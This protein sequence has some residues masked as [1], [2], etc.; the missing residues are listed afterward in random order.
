MDQVTV[1][2]SEPPAAV[3]SGMVSEAIAAAMR[4]G[5]IEKRPGLTFGGHLLKYLEPE[6]R[7]AK[8]LWMVGRALEASLD[9]RAQGQGQ[10]VEAI[11]GIANPAYFDS[12]RLSG[13]NGRTRKPKVT[14]WSEI[15]GAGTLQVRWRPTRDKVK[16][17]GESVSG[18][19]TD[20]V[21]TPATWRE[22]GVADNVILRFKQGTFVEWSSGQV[23]EADGLVA[24]AI[25][26]LRGALVETLGHIL[27]AL[28]VHCEVLV[29]DWPEYFPDGS[30]K[31]TSVRHRASKGL[32]M[33]RESASADVRKRKEDVDSRVAKLGLES[34]EQFEAA[35]SKAE[36]SGSRL[37]ADLFAMTGQRCTSL[38][39][40]ALAERLDGLRAV[41][42]L[43]DAIERA[44]AKLAEADEALMLG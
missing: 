6:P 23:T 14:L 44:K 26:G 21:F 18:V 37:T 43:L 1:E 31:L 13:A 39:T 16:A 33:E 20:Y 41:E 25:D 27:D 36:S 15:T 7:L 17:T 2:S 8:D 42:E 29:E 19:G 32:E 22:H 24:R 9:I 4:P 5:A 10:I 38:Q 30:L 40:D 34:I 12:V 35:R 3:V 28:Q 11:A